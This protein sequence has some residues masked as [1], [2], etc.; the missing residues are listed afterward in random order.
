MNA[1]IFGK[2]GADRIWPE[3]TSLNGDLN[4]DY[5]LNMIAMGTATSRPIRAISPKSS[6]EI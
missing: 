2:A 1:L 6:V 5:F 3:L 4:A